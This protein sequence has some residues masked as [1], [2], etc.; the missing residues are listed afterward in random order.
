MNESFQVSDREEAASIAGLS[1]VV[2]TVRPDGTFEVA[3]RN[4][5]F[6]LHVNCLLPSLTRPGVIP[7]CPGPG[8]S[9]AFGDRALESSFHLASAGCEEIFAAI[10]KNDLQAVKDLCEEN[11]PIACAL[12]QDFKQPIHSATTLNDSNILS[13]LLQLDEVIIDSVDI[14]GNTPLHM[15]MANENLEISQIL[16]QCQSKACDIN[17]QNARGKSALIIA[18]SMGYTEKVSLLLAKGCDVNLFDGNG[19]TALFSSITHGKTEVALAILHT[20]LVDY[21][22][23]TVKDVTYLHQ[24]CAKG[25]IEVVLKLLELSPDLINMVDKNS[26]FS[27]LYL[28]VLNNKEEIV[29]ILIDSGATVNLASKRRVNA[30]MI[31]VAS[32]NLRV[33]SKLVSAGINLSHVDIEYNN[34]LAHLFQPMPNVVKL[35][36]YEVEEITGDIEE[37]AKLLQGIC[38]DSEINRD[39]LVACYLISKGVKYKGIRNKANQTPL[40]IC[41][42]E[43][44]VNVIENFIKENSNGTSYSSAECRMCNKPA[45]C[46]FKPCDHVIS[47]GDC[48]DFFKR[49]YICKEAV[50]SHKKIT[51]TIQKICVLCDELEANVRFMPCNHNEVCLGCA[52]RIKKCI[53]CQTVITG[54]TDLQGNDASTA[55]M[56]AVAST[57]GAS[58]LFDGAS[59]AARDAFGASNEELAQLRSKLEQLEDAALCQI[60]IERP[61]NVV[62]LCGHIFCQVCAS[63]LQLCP[64]CRQVVSRMIPIYSG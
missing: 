16:L 36:A 56:A 54:K 48:V 31:A 37:V 46:Q 38:V 24:A 40:Q 60:C 35:T 23:K 45:N 6:I 26:E 29:N 58:S 64:I 7:Y 63:S 8:P 57:S 59:G 3:I 44:V 62:F 49:C 12:R 4:R 13:Y 22:M 28:A 50:E 2:K 15:A 43:S 14:E 27:P 33:I 55:A 47:C 11:H 9:G 52:P 18:A 41:K 5:R 39:A 20:G 32:C 1:G 19:E 21:K 34:C 30:L 10:S 17:R 42:E 51:I 25:N 53:K 61:K